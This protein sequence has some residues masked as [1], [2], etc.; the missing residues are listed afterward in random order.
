MSPDPAVKQGRASY[1]VGT[2]QRT[3]TTQTRT[4]RAHFGVMLAL[5][6]D[7]CRSVFVKTRFQFLATS[8][9]NNKIAL[10]TQ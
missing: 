1:L 8:L 10:A 4:L 6:R 7:P 9:R 2:T 3:Y 5:L